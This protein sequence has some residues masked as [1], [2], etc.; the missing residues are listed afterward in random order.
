M[1]EFNMSDE[2][3]LNQPFPEVTGSVGDESDETND[4][5][6]EDINV[7]ES[8]DVTVEEEALADDEDDVTEE[9]SEE[10]ETET[11]SEEEVSEDS[12][13]E[14][15]IDDATDEGDEESPDESTVN[16]EE[17][18]SKL[19]QPFK[20]A[21]K[22]FQVN[23]VDEAITLMQKGIGFNKKMSTIAPHM[24]TI[25]TLEQH[26]LLDESKINFLI[27]LDKKNPEAI[28][29][30][31]QDSKIDPL[32]LSAD[33]ETTYTSTNYG[34]TDVQVAL[35]DEMDSIKDTPTYGQTMQT[36]ERWDQKSTEEV[37]KE[38]RLLSVI[39]DHIAL[40]VYDKINT[41]LEREKL[42]GNLNGMS[43]LE[44]YQHVGDT[45]HKEGAFNEPTPNTDVTA[46]PTKSRSTTPD[47]KTKAK[48]KAAGITK[49]RSNSVR[50]PKQTIDF[51]LSDEE[52]LKLD[53]K[54]T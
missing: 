23:S 29:K 24:K 16:Y 22:E 6:V 50:K 12:D 5:V 20:A 48:K 52:F 18:Y 37:V 15:D 47:P 38:P 11:D 27:D 13:S 1:S 43:D 36:I 53:P 34:V 44:A 21:G 40:G 33:E 35:A 17:E 19:L 41:R 30:L 26:G 42:L 2:D 28:K 51:N 4:E 3:F 9:E 45:L 25:R 8:D 7:E 49:N 39:N 54:F 31:V 10:D 32:D 46:T 14:E